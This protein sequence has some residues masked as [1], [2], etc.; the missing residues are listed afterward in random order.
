MVAP[1]DFGPEES[2]ET[3]NSGSSVAAFGLNGDAKREVSR[4]SAYCSSRTVE[5]VERHTSSESSSALPPTGVGPTS[6]ESPR[7][8]TVNPDVDPTCLT[9]LLRVCW[10]HFVPGPPQGSVS[11]WQKNQMEPHLPAVLTPLAT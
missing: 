10:S 6:G 5:D 1:I 9:H 8:T 4:A 11:G 3:E 2:H 7:T